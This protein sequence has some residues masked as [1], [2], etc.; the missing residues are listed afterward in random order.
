MTHPICRVQSFQI[1]APYILR[2]HI[3][4]GTEQVINFESVLAGELF[5]PSPLLRGSFETSSQEPPLKL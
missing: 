2:V 1:V 3:D 5:G 4:D